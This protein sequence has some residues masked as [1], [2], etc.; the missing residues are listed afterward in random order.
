MISHL[1]ELLKEKGG[2]NALIIGI[3][4]VVIWILISGFVKG[5]KKAK[6]DKNSKEK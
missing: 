2:S 4:I 5:L 1:W 3:I 6:Q